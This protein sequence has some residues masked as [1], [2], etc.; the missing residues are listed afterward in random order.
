MPF[1]PSYF[2]IGTYEDAYII[3]DS[4]ENGQ[5]FELAV[6][7]EKG[8]GGSNQ[9]RVDR[10]KVATSIVH[11]SFHD[12]E[13]D[14]SLVKQN[15]VKLRRRGVEVFKPWYKLTFE[16]YEKAKEIYDRYAACWPDSATLPL[17][18]EGEAAPNNP[19]TSGSSTSG[20]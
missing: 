4:D 18:L 11:L 5:F 7:F 13:M 19:S 14:P 16:S 9:V 8:R 17:G 10:T 12:M 20:S 6:V 15:E 1:D 2:Y 3:Y